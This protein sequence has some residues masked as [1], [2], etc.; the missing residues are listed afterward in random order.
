MDLPS[1]PK[2]LAPKPAPAPLQPLQLLVNTRDTD[3]GWDVLAELSAARLW[4]QR[5]EMIGAR[6]RFEESDLEELRELR[7]S[8]RAVLLSNNGGPPLTSSQLK[9]MRELLS[10]SSPTFELDASGRI[11]LAARSKSDLG[12]VLMAVLLAVRDAQ[13]DGTWSRLKVCRND[14]CGWAFF[15]RS[16]NRNGSWCD[17]AV[18]GNREKNRSFRVR[19]RQDD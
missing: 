14:A 7:E 3:E 17:M 8:L 16:R 18:C 1:R 4:L 2:Q 6:T 10:A 5:E 9:P 15:D 11:D 19:H 12:G 13:A